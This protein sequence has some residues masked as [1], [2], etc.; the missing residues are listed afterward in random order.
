MRSAKVPHGDLALSAGQRVGA[1]LVE[2]KRSSGVDAHGIARCTLMAE[3]WVS[4]ASLRNCWIPPGPYRSLTHLAAWAPESPQAVRVN[5]V[6]KGILGL[7]PS[8]DSGK[9]LLTCE[10][11]FT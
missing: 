1:Y 3:G 9:F 5:R 2:N 7:T 6:F 11:I 4:Q 10:K 8:W